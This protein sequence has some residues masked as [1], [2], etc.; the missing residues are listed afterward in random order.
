[1]CRVP[2]S[3]FSWRDSRACWS[4]TRPRRPGS[5]VRSV[6]SAGLRARLFRFRCG[7][8]HVGSSSSPPTTTTCT[9]CRQ[10][11][12]LTRGALKARFRRRGLPSPYAYIRWLRIIACAHLLSD[13]TITVA[14]TAR[15]FGYTSAGN[16][17]RTM[18]SL[19]GLTPTEARTQNGRNHLADRVRAHRLERRR[20]R[21]VEGAG[22]LSSCVAVSPSESACIRPRCIRGQKKRPSPRGEDRLGQGR[23][24]PSAG[25]AAAAGAR[26]GWRPHASACAGRSASRSSGACAA[27]STDRNA[28][29]SA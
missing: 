26:A 14:R 20:A 4:V 19:T 17:C 25:S 21:G 8:S 28:A 22:G 23:R 5:T 10:A 16:L 1:M 29:P 24:T 7:R 2:G 13:G 18:T 27:R 11:C 3:T 12:G 9:R 6:S 15:R